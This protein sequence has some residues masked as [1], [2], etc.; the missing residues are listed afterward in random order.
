MLPEQSLFPPGIR[1]IR[2]TCPGT[3]AYASF[4]CTTLDKME[5]LGNTGYSHIGLYIHGVEYEKQ[6]GSK[7]CGTYMSILF[8]SLADP[9][10][11]GREE[12]G[13]PKLYSAI[14][15]HQEVSSFRIQNFSS[16]HAPGRKVTPSWGTRK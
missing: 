1:N 12:L 14:D 3:I 6:N 13:I 5:W 11:S 8:E 9:I 16:A 4:A 2:F 10:I 15:I 7:I